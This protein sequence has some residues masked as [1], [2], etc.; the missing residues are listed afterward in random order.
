V[1][2]LTGDDMP[3]LYFSDYGG[4]VLDQIGQG[5]ESS[6]LDDRLLINNGT[7]F[8]TDQT[9]TRLTADMRES[10]FGTDV[11]IADM[12]GDGFLDIVKTDSTGFDFNSC[13][14]LLLDDDPVWAGATRGSTL[15]ERVPEGGTIPNPSVTIIYNDG[16]GDFINGP[17]WDAVQSATP[18][19]TAVGDFTQDDRLDLFVV[20][21]SQDTYLVNTGNGGDGMANFATTTINP[22]AASGF[23][24][25]VTF[26]DMDGDDIL[27]VLIA[28]VDTDIPGCSRH[29]WILRGTGTPPN[30]SYT[31]PLAGEQRPWTPNG[32]FDVA[33]FD[34]NG[35]GSTDLVIGT[36]SGTKIFMGP[37]L[38]I[39]NDGFESGD[40]D[41]W[42]S[43]AN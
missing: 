23:G 13:A 22:P 35:D 43:T 33:P 38:N 27:D 15:A 42:D 31:D 19:M 37:D 30:I 5:G 6:D 32:T 12:N 29:L 20:D 14:S 4:L 3:D 26:A 25:N 34:I 1:G 28:D 18:Y 2:D 17:G 9:A 16:T 7:G 10:L 24:G 8:F 36:C 41:A 39:F 40:T 11:D 21:D